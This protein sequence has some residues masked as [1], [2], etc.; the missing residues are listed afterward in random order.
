[1]KSPI[2]INTSAAEPSTAIV[3]VNGFFIDH[4]VVL[5]PPRMHIAHPTAPSTTTPAVT[6]PSSGQSHSWVT[7]TAMATAAP[8]R[9]VV[10]PSLHVSL[11]GVASFV[12][13]CYQPPPRIA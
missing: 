13:S 1:M 8:A 4:S 9:I 10:A 11:I 7:A 6:L 3:T 12:R 5:V 2:T